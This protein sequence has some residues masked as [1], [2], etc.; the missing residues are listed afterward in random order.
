MDVWEPQWSTFYLT[1]SSL[2]S[3]TFHPKLC[4]LVIYPAKRA[5][6]IGLNKC[7]LMVSPLSA[8]AISGTQLSLAWKEPTKPLASVVFKSRKTKC[9][10]LTN[11][12]WKLAVMKSQV[13]FNS[14]LKIKLHI[15]RSIHVQTGLKNRSNLFI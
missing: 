3:L 12:H 1:I 14:E 9:C 4:Y 7:F 8:A 2:E 10:S 5:T 13:Y 11:D 6:T 15:K